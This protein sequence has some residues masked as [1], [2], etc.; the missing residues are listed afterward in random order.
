V[1]MGMLAGGR[2][3]GRVSN[4]KLRGRFGIS[5]FAAIFIIIFVIVVLTLILG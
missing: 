5:V 4:R 3:R 1:G 2:R